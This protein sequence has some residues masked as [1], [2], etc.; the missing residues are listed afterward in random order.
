M[1]APSSTAR[2]YSS[3]RPGD[4]S[5]WERRS[6][7]TR[8]SSRCSSRTYAG[9]RKARRGVRWNW[10][11]PCAFWLAVSDS[12]CNAS[13]CGKE[14]T[15][16]NRYR[17]SRGRERNAPA[18]ARSVSTA[19]SIAPRT[20]NASKSSSIAPRYRRR[21]ERRGRLGERA[22]FEVCVDAVPA[23]GGGFADSD[24][25]HRRL[26]RVHPCAPD[27]LARMTAQ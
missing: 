2:R 5:S 26:E 17:W 15:W 20:G 27:G 10:E 3:T 19:S 1:P 23:S 24:L 12:S 6:R 11:S 7:T 18:S 21:T 25:E 8:K 9:Y 4:G 16:T 13:S 14:P 22:G